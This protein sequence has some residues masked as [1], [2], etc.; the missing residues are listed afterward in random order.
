MRVNINDCI[1]QLGLVCFRIK[2]DP[3]NKLNKKLLES[4]NDS[5]K[6]HMVPAMVHDKFVIRFC[7]VAQHATESDIGTSSK[8]KIFHLR[9]LDKVLREIFYFQNMHGKLSEN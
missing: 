9:L 6:L 8:N 1:F 5:G 3:S 2:N 4:I 7:V